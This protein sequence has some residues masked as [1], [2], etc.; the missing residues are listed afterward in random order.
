MRGTVSSEQIG[1]EIETEVALKAVSL[2]WL[3]NE[4]HL[5]TET[6]NLLSPYFLSM[7]PRQIRTAD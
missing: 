7:R 4:R 3:T 1:S 5:N 6:N 2:P